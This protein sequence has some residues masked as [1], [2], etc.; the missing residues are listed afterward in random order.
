MR[1][2]STSDEEIARIIG[3]GGR[4]GE[5][6]AGLKALRDKYANVIRTRFPNLPRRVSGYNLDQLLPENGFHVARALVGTEGT[7]VTV[8]EATTR[9]VHSPPARSLLVLGYSDAYLAADHVPQIMAHGPIGLEGFDRRLVE[10]MRKKHLQLDNIALLPEGGGWLLVE[11][12]GETRQEA[13]DR[14]RV[15]AEELRRAMN[16]P[17]MKLCTNYRR[18]RGS[19]PC[20]KRAWEPLFLYLASLTAGRAGKTRLCHLRSWVVT[21]ETCGS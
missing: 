16:A 7:C 18:R 12:G 2:G 3:E 4:R 14:A 9:L 20:V 1:V 10:N 5:I 17:S 8:M 15:L 13:E 19:G 21:C 6:Y 11:F